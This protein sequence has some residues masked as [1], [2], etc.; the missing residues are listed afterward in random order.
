MPKEQLPDVMTLRLR[1]GTF[2]RIDELCVQN[3]R[4]EWIRDAVE[5][6]LE[7]RERG[8]DQP[9]STPSP[10]RQTKTKADLDA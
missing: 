10:S 1:K 7:R 6:E 3:K 9:A 5:A 8:R 4:A 2:D